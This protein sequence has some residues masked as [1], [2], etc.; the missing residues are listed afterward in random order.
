MSK[1]EKSPQTTIT[2]S[3][4][5]VSTALEALQTLVRNGKP[6]DPEENYRRQ[7][8]LAT[9]RTLPP[10]F[11]PG[12]PRRIACRSLQTNSTFYADVQ[13]SPVTDDRG[14]VLSTRWVIKDLRDYTLP[15]T[16][17]RTEKRDNE[18][19]SYPDTSN[20]PASIK[21]KLRSDGGY[22]DAQ[23]PLGHTFPD[24]MNKNHFHWI[25]F[26]QPDFATYV[27]SEYRDEYS[28]DF[29]STHAEQL[30]A[31]RARQAELEARLAEAEA[32]G[33]VA[34]AVKSEHRI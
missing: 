25:H 30:E 8:W 28:V 32:A 26:T 6:L 22:P 3:P 7:V 11:I 9:G 23:S 24:E 29:Q 17:I 16:E 1:E 2:L 10:R 19:R 27:G 18:L 21:A 4:E 13:E 15:P 34:K 20:W 14:N 5:I 33:F 31:A 12:E